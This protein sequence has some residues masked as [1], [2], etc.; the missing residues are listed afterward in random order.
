M[1]EIIMTEFKETIQKLLDSDVSGYQI[2]KET[3]ISQSRI[4]DLRKGNRQLGG[5]A[6]DT[7]EK[8]YNYQKS[9]ENVES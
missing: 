5:I 7:T 4:S 9:L 1:V 3:G 2:Y 8:L 6:L